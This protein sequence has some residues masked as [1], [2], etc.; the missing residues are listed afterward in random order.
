MNLALKGIKDRYKEKPK[1]P[2]DFTL[3]KEICRLITQKQNADLWLA[4]LC[5]A[6]FAGLRSAEYCNTGDPKI[7][8]P[9]VASVQFDQANRIL[10]YTV[11][12]SKTSAT[13]F[14][15]PLGC[16]RIPLC[17]YCTMLY[18]MASRKKQGTLHRSA[19]LFLL[20]GSPPFSS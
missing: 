12:R 7:G 15:V 10:Y 13:G 3:F 18:Y 2:I 5:L 1:E 9:L 11:K 6:F 19:P 16:T 17:A 20:Q 14:T 8:S 4:V